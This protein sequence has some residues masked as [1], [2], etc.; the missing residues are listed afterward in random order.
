M[1]RRIWSLVGVAA[2]VA[3][4]VPAFVETP[5]H[6]I[7]NVTPSA[8]VGLYRVDP[9]AQPE[10]HDLVAL[11]APE[12]LESLLAERG[13]LP[14]NIP[15]LKHVVG[16]PGQIVCRVGRTITVDGAVMGMA[17]E[18][19]SFGRPMPVW[20]GCQRIAADDIF[21]MNPAVETSLDGR[22][23]GPMPVQSI[24]G[25]AVSLWTDEDR[26]SPIQGRVNSQ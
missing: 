23:F 24:I 14:P 20:Q 11:D 18:H 3:I 10:L 1:K 19:D 17:Q 26:A 13:Y 16:L 8:P 5:A 6:L 22:Y 4:T 9:K 25:R 7:W 15:L 21:L 2:I 12:A